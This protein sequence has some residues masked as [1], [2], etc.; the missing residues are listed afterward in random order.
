MLN[1][2]S[3]NFSHDADSY[4]QIYYKLKYVLQKKPINYLILNTDYFMFSI[5]LDTRNYVYCDYFDNNYTLDYSH[6]ALYTFQKKAE[7]LLNNIH[8][9]NLLHLRSNKIDAFL[10]DNGQYIKPGKASEKDKIDR[11]IDRLQF[12]VDY[13]EKVLYL[14]KQEKIRVFIVTLPTRQ[15]ELDSYSEA[16][17]KEFNTFISTYVNGNDVFYFNHSLDHNFKT[18]D[19]T[20][21]THLNESA[22]DRFSKIL[23]NNIMGLIPDTE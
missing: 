16:Q 3:L 20:D 4:N 9:K 13:F 18:N 15:E 17:I 12:Q 2:P 5:K 23:N 19:F 10:K 8:P 7:Y 22:A 21:I 11:N 6:N 14:C 1:I